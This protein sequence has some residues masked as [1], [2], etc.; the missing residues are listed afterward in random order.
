MPLQPHCDLRQG[1]ICPNAT[2]PYNNRMPETFLGDELSGTKRYRLIGM[3][4]RGTVQVRLGT[5]E[6]QANTKTPNHKSPSSLFTTYTD[7]PTQR[8]NAVLISSDAGISRHPRASIGGGGDACCGK[9]PPPPVMTPL[10][11]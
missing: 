10:A 3:G 4:A 11:S 5:G 6:G 1:C 8:P 2:R 7:V 9:L